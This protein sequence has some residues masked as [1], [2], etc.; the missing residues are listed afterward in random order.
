[1]GAGGAGVFMRLSALCVSHARLSG[2]VLGLASALP[3]LSHQLKQS[4][5]NLGLSPPGLRNSRAQGAPGV[6]SSDLDRCLFDAHP[7]P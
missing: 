3:E 1:M 6:V 2:P 7:H 5:N 4:G